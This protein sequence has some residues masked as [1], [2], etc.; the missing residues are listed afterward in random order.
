MFK[1]NKIINKIKNNHNI[2]II[3]KNLN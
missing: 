1:K 2:K 3:K